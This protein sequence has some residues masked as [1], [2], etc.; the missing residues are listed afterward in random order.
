MSSF[1]GIR[2]ATCQGYPLQ[3]CLDSDRLPA[4][5]KNI[6]HLSWWMSETDP[7]VYFSFDCE[8]QHGKINQLAWT[9]CDV[10]TGKMRTVH[11]IDRDELVHVL[12]RQKK[13]KKTKKITVADFSFGQPPPPGAVPPVD[14]KI[15]AQ[16]TCEIFWNGSLVLPTHIGFVMMLRD[17]SEAAGYDL[18]VWIHLFLWPRTAIL[19]S[20]VHQQAPAESTCLRT[21]PHHRLPVHRIRTFAESPDEA[22]ARVLWLSCPRPLACN[23][24]KLASALRGVDMGHTMKF[25][26]P[27][28]SVSPTLQR[29][30]CRRGFAYHNA[31]I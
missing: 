7:D 4:G 17:L 19:C 14:P 3:R 2:A 30:L 21:Q 27:A 31:G 24:G 26:N 23:V 18:S 1:A 22:D 11:V 6:R 28:R 10:R 15:P 9:I 13:Q 12:E 5:R 8:Y 20:S 29:T 16:L 25:R